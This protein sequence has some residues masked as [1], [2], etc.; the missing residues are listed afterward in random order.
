MF[1]FKVKDASGNEAIWIVDAKNGK[2]NV[3]FGGTG[4]SLDHTS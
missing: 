2:G 4:L 3:E 1:A